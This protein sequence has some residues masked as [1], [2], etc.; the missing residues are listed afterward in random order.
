MRLDPETL[1]RFRNAVRDDKATFIF[2]PSAA[3]KEM[4]LKQSDP[5][6]N[7]LPKGMPEH[8]MACPQGSGLATDADLVLKFLEGTLDEKNAYLLS[9]GEIRVVGVGDMFI[10][11]PPA[12][13]K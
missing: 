3:L 4:I 1:Q 13:P 5:I 8:L 11:N 10:K 2:V 7:S 6:I 12:K 9:L